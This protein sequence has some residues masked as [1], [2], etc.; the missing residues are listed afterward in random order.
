MANAPLPLEI[1]MPGGGIQA[2]H[3]DVVH[4]PDGF[5]GFPYWMACTPYPF[6]IDLE[7]NPVIRVSLDGKR[8]TA[9]PSAPDP[10]Q[11]RPMDPDWHHADTDLVLDGG[12]LHLFYLSTNRRNG[13]TRF[14]F[15][16]SADGC[17]WTGPQEFD[18]GNWGVS[19][20]VVVDRGIWRLWYVR[21]DT[22]VH[23]QESV[24]FQRQGPSPASLGDPVACELAIPGYVPWHL[25]V[26][27][28]PSGFE[29]LI[30]AFPAG[31]NS[32][33]CCLFHAVSKDGLSFR[34]SRNGPLLGPSWF[35][36]D[37]R[38]IYRSTFAKDREGRYQ[39]W[40]SASSWGHR[41]GI[42]LL[43]GDLQDLK[44][45]AGTSRSGTRRIRREDVVGWTKYLATR[46][47][48]PSIL[49]WVRK[50]RA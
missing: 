10:L 47:L 42:G 2:V 41:W 21:C 48:H 39:I 34:L 8:W 30:A 46:T 28:V 49:A 13:E 43:Q 33:K 15:L 5:L 12:R 16:T 38:L 50:M 17:H 31:T 26:I 35:G 22:H 40:Y 14:C 37:N 23:R 24:L 45:E 6:G 11:N 1:P 36:W 19:P 4:V 18:P 44:P 32:S 7:E 3:P 27:G 9:F 20:A 29:A 25:D